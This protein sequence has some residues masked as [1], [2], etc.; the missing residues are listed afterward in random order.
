MRRSRAH[1]GLAWQV[2]GTVSNIIEKIYSSESPDDKLLAAEQ[3]P[4]S[5]DVTLQGVNSN[6]S[7]WQQEEEE[8]EGSCMEQGGEMKSIFI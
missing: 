8:E 2:F 5:D 6:S 7:F 1:T 3:I 4:F